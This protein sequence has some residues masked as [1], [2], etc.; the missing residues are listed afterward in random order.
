MNNDHWA[1]G[2]DIELADGR[3]ATVAAVD[4]TAA[5]SRVETAGGDVVAGTAIERIDWGGADA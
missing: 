3:C 5:P 2:H 4:A 1:V